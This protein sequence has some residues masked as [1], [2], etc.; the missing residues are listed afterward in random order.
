MGLTAARASALSVLVFGGRPVT[1]GA[2]AQAE[3]VSAPTITRLIVGMERDG[4]VRRE[5]DAADGRVVWLHAT[6]K[7]AR[8]LHAGRRRRVAALEADLARPRRP[9]SATRSPTPP[10]S[11]SA[12]SATQASGVTAERAG[13]ADGATWR[14]GRHGRA[15]SDDAD[16]CPSLSRRCCWRRAPMQISARSRSLQPGE[17]VVL[18]IALPEAS[19][20][21]RVR[22]F[23]RDVAAY[24]DGER[25]WR[26]LV[27]I[28]LDVKPGT[29]RG[30][31]RRRCRGAAAARQLRSRS[32]S[33]ASSARGG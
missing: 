31:G 27:G 8:L 22:A 11:S 12:C 9:R 6:A 20:T 2:L 19:G 10:P 16:R 21:I 18:S 32:S 28:D 7:G 15:G 29:Y 3:Q 24:P 26:A 23:D 4:L 14:D 33:R 17:L 5:A 30:D 13:S 25:A 1:L